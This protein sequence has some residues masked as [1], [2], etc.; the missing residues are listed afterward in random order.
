VHIIV[1]LGNHGS[2]YENTRHNVGLA[3][4]DALCRK[5]HLKLKSGIGDYLIGHKSIAGQDIILVKP[6]TYMNNSG[7]AVQDILHKYNAAPE[8]L[9]IVVDDFH[10]P[11]GKIRI[12]KKGSS[13]GH[14]GLSSL[15]Y[16]LNTDEFARMRCGIGN[17]EM[18]GYNEN[19]ANFVL[20]T[21]LESEKTRFN[22]MVEAACDAVTVLVMKDFE[23][24]LRQFNNKQF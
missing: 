18:P 24:A 11:L 5:W 12:R 14:N 15:I 1:G 13:G 8:N 2:E 10:L 20:S 4:V 16:S 22:K 6:L 19:T 21:F 23:S 7:I 3:V 17:E 9:L